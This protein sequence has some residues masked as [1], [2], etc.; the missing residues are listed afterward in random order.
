MVDR[1]QIHRRFIVQLLLQLLMLFVFAFVLNITIFILISYFTEQ[2]ESVEDL[3]KASDLFIENRVEVEA[4]TA[5]IEQGLKIRVEEQDGWLAVLTEEGKVIGSHNTPPSLKGKRMETLLYS[6]DNNISTYW[7]W[8]EFAEKQYYV[9]FGKHNWQKNIM[10]EIKENISWKN[11]K[12]ELLGSVKTKLDKIDG[13]ALLVDYTGKTLDSYGKD[14]PTSYPTKDLIAIEADQKWSHAKSYFHEPSRLTLIVG[15]EPTSSSSLA[16]NMEGKISNSVIVVAVF[17]ILFLLLATYWYAHKFSSPLLMFIRWLQNLGHGSYEQPVHPRTGQPMLFNK[18]GDIKRKYRLYKDLFFTL[19]QLTDIL[20]ERDVERRR[21]SRSREEWV[22]GISHD[23]KTPLASIQGYANMMESDAYSWNEAE[24][25]EFASVI[26]KKSTYM[27]DLIEDLNITYQLKNRELPITKECTDMNECI[28]RTIL[29]FMNNKLYA[30]KELRFQ[31][32]HNEIIGFI[33]RKWFQRIMDNVI[34]NA[35]KYNPAGTI[36][37]ISTELIE[38]HVM[39]IKIVDNGVGMDNQ[40]VNH[41][42]TRYY[43]GTNTTETD[44]G[45]GLGMAISKQLIALHNGSIRVQS[46]PG[47]GTVIRI[48]LP[49]S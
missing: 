43:R 23:L 12:L 25:R 28:R 26:S 3:T 8:G 18:Y 41:L 40:T 42:F 6:E 35:I 32:S 2:T 27:K 34:A 22:S 36:I 19:T 17:V 13:W 9:V 29:Q 46:K 5:E 7:V 45:T 20:R 15:E 47:E 37:T 1:M 31:P 33:D 14:A 30:D 4:G 39:V 38:Q 16:G 21:I 48:L 44:S 24:I 11:Q 49:L 10:Q